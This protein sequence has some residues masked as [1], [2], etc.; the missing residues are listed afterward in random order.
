VAPPNAADSA[1]DFAGERALLQASMVQGGVPPKA[2][3]CLTDHAVARPDYQQ[4]VD[5][6]LSSSEPS[7]D[8]LA[9]FEQTLGE[10]ARGCPS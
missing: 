6:A 4:F 9:S 5:V 10:L 7:K 1:L 2:A 8:Q 3:V